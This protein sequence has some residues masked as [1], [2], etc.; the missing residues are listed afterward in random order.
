MT[1]HNAYRVDILIGW[2]LFFTFHP[3]MHMQSTIFSKDPHSQ[4]RPIFFYVLYDIKHSNQMHILIT[5]MQVHLKE[6]Y[7]KERCWFSRF[8]SHQSFI[9]RHES[10]ITDPIKACFVHLLNQYYVKLPAAFFVYNRF[11]QHWLLCLSHA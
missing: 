11:Q 3:L 7:P 9:L 4:E 2:W 1:D 6:S 10:S 5:Y 8:F